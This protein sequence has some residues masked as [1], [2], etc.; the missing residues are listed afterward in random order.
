MISFS[1][2]SKDTMDNLID[3]AHSASISSP[4]VHFDP[5]VNKAVAFA[6]ANALIN[7]GKNG[8]YYLTEKGIKLVNEIDNDKSIL[9]DEKLDLNV[10]SIKLTDEKIKDLSRNWRESNAED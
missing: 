6:I 3:Y 2:S 8:K 4:T 9:F 10:L 5:A 1:L 7:Q